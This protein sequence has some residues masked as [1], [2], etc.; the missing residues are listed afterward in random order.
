MNPWI[1]L[2]V[3]AVCVLFAAR[4]EIFGGWRPHGYGAGKS[5]RSVPEDACSHSWEIVSVSHT[6]GAF[7][8]SDR[9]EGQSA[10]MRYMELV[11]TLG[12]GS[13]EIALR[14]KLCG[15]F[16]GESVPGIHPSWKLG[17]RPDRAP[18]PPEAASPN[19]KEN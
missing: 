9:V 2:G 18:L 6:K 5:V 13:T 10:V 16:R 8:K 15:M 14:C 3:L 4:V 1:A 11:E 19:K 7:F 12:K 17:E